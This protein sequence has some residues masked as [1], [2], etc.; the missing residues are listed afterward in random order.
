MDEQSN[1]QDPGPESWSIP[2]HFVAA[3]DA[4]DASLPARAPPRP[5]AEDDAL[6]EGKVDVTP[7]AR[8][9]IHGNLR[10]RLARFVAFWQFIGASALVIAWI[11]NGYPLPFLSAA[12]PAPT[13]FKN[14][15]GAE[16][17]GCWLDSALEELLEAGAVRHVLQRP[18]VCSP[19][20][21]VGKGGP[22]SGK[23]RLI[24]DLRYVNL[25]CEKF[26]FT[27]ETLAR[28]RSMILPG[29]WMFSIDLT[30]AYHHVEIQ[31][32]DQQYMGFCWRGKYYVFCCLPFGGSYSPAAFTR[33]SK[34]ITLFL[35]RCG[36]RLLHYLDDYLFVT[37]TLRGCARLIT[38]VVGVFRAAGFL[39]NLDK[40]VL[41]PVQ[42]I[43][44][45]GFI[46][47]TRKFTFEVIPDR[48]VRLVKLI[49]AVSK[50][51][52]I[53]R[54]QVAKVCGTLQSMRM[55]LGNVVATFTFFL[56]RVIDSVFSWRAFVQLSAE[57][58]GE[59]RFWLNYF[60]RAGVGSTFIRSARSSPHVILE[61]DASDSHWAGVLKNAAGDEMLRTRG[62]FSIEESEWSSTWREYSTYVHAI[63]TLRD[64]L[65]GLTILIKTD[66]MSAWH[67]F[68]RGS[69][70]IRAIQELVVKLFFLIPDVGI[71]LDM[72]WWPREMG[73]AAD[74]ASK[75]VLPGE[76]AIRPHL[77]QFLLT[78]F[79]VV[80][81]DRFASATNGVFIETP[82]KIRRLPYCSRYFVRDGFCLG[83]AFSTPWNRS[84]F[85][86]VFP[87]FNLIERAIARMLDQEARGIL[88]IPEWPSATWWPSLF[89]GSRLA[90]FVRDRVHVG[91]F[92][93]CVVVAADGSALRTDSI[94]TLLALSFDC[95]RSVAEQVGGASQVRA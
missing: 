86:W 74:I 20:D 67:I 76:W 66:S 27:M 2:A 5:P 30:S 7:D 43:T 4:E 36:V 45:L 90:W 10:G 44:S 88:L 26:K 52:S 82:Q 71:T 37:H 61:C 3:A 11:M 87:S 25:F 65:R 85:N 51:T 94:Y 12:R 21:V 80:T 75:E 68:R 40:S 19:L 34:Q 18:T 72:D 9:K 50:S 81:V 32:E 48:I 47:D 38:F 6:E 59:L 14:A 56:Y 39:I 63:S 53:P 57:A 28:R 93:D 62:L 89:H 1:V 42:R 95:R 78:L 16:Q 55:V 22:N 64:V 24:L 54:K 92:H 84:S 77:F 70:H 91:W 29:S 33:L 41:T 79:G 17:H 35:R 60:R 83:D 23:F 31:E 15:A 8:L 13:F 46:I 73:T 49:T 58:L 69:S